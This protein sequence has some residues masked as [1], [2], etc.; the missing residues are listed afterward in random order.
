MTALVDIQAVPDLEVGRRLL[1]QLEDAPDAD[2]R[3]MLRDFTVQIDIELRAA[4]LSLLVSSAVAGLSLGA[5]IRPPSRRP[6]R[7]APK[8][9]ATTCP[10]TRRQSHDH[11]SPGCRHALSSASVVS[12][13]EEIRRMPFG[14]PAWNQKN[15][16]PALMQKLASALVACQ[17]FALS[18]VCRRER[19]HAFRARR[20]LRGGVA[21]DHQ[22][23]RSN[24]YRSRRE[25]VATVK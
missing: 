12:T 18:R 5:L 14:N 17:A 21:P 11:A 7:S 10:L 1:G 3:R 25:Y 23:E 8:S 16:E 20:S 22:A 2:V 15:D 9:G 13:T 6:P 19:Q 4:W 24:V